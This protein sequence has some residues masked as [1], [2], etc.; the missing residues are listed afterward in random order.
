MPIDDDALSSEIL[1][2]DR[3]DDSQVAEVATDDITSNIQ[4]V[5]FVKV[6][7]HSKTCGT[8]CIEVLYW[9]A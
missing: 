8:T 5:E 9:D 6:I 3:F 1:H 7:R 2:L 4:F